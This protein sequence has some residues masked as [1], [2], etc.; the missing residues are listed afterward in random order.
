MLLQST[1][2]IK[3]QVLLTSS[4][5]SLLTFTTTCW[6]VV[7]TPMKSKLGL[8]TW[9][10]MLG[11]VQ[12][13]FPIC[14][15]GTWFTDLTLLASNQTMEMAAIKAN[16]QSIEQEATSYKLK[17]MASMLL[18]VLGQHCK[19]LHLTYM[20]LRAFPWV[21]QQQWLQ[22]PSILSKFNLVISTAITWIYWLS[23]SL[24][25]TT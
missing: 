15:N 8:F 14:T 22:E 25:I 16:W 6:L 7:T 5:S 4:K 2:L 12:F 1:L 17:L 23:T 11:S 13:K 21:S 20:H 24:T 10:T 9:I 3:S 18:I 19:L